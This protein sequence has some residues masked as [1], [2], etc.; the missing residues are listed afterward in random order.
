MFGAK[1]RWLGVKVDLR[2]VMQRENADHAHDDCGDHNLHDGPV[3]QKKLADENM[4]GADATFL[5]QKAKSESEYD[6]ADDH[7]GGCRQCRLIDLGFF[8]RFARI[9]H[10]L[11][12]KH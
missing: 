7:L 4:V 3:L 2:E 11:N 9:E 6:A 5:Q 8:D 1:F 10:R 12:P